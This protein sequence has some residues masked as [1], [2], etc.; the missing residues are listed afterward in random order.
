MHT[1][2]LKR[3]DFLVLIAMGVFA[4]PTIG[5]AQTPH[6]ERPLDVGLI[7]VGA[8]WC[9]QCHMAAPLVRIAALNNDLPLLVASADDKAIPPFEHFAPAST[10]PIARQVKAYPSLLIWS[11]AENRIVARVDGIRTPRRYI[12]RLNTTFT[13]LREQGYVR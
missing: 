3:R 5:Q 10:H 12:A 4:T 1:H 11:S 2:S 13:S 7:F 6:M 8:S 9:P